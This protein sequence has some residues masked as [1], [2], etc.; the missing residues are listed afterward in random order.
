MI[1]SLLLE[2]PVGTFSHRM[3]ANPLTALFANA[4]GVAGGSP[5]LPSVPG[6]ASAKLSTKPGIDQ[7]KIVGTR[8]SF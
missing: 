1:C 5:I 3:K 2:A 8:T 7:A 6:S 4:T